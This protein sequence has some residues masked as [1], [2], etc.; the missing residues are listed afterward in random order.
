M[1]DY[2][3]DKT[4]TPTNSAADST[5]TMD[6]T[7][8]KTIAM[9]STEDKDTYSKK[10]LSN[11]PVI[12]YDKPSSE[13][14]VIYDRTN[15]NP[16][17]F[18][19]RKALTTAYSQGKR[20]IDCAITAVTQNILSLYN[21][22]KTLAQTITLDSGDISSSDSTITVAQTISKTDTSLSSSNDNTTTDGGP[23]EPTVSNADSTITMDRTESNTSSITTE[24]STVV[25]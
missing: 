7:T 5:I 8:S 13:P 9:G 24:V 25:A 19:A 22:G 12:F 21:I 18:H 20:V 3:I 23:I 11:I 2:T 4:V 16:V 10:I 1:S 15:G 6:K 17:I 14:V